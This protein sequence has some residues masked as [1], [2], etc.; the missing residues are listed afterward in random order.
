MID[1][2]IELDPREPMHRLARGVAS[3]DA[4]RDDQ[5]ERERLFETARA[6]FE[7]ARSLAPLDPDHTQN[8]AR[9]WA[10]R[11]FSA[12][13]DENRT[14]HLRHA[15]REYRSAISMRP[16]SAQLMM[17]L[18]GVLEALGETAELRQLVERAVELDPSSPRASIKLAALYRREAELARESGDQARADRI[19]GLGLQ[20]LERAGRED[21]GSAAVARAEAGLLVVAGRREDAITAYQRYMQR[22]GEDW[23]VHRVLAL[24][25]AEAGDRAA[26]IRHAER[27]MAVAG[28]GQ[29][30]IAAG[31]LRQVRGTSATGGEPQR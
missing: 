27:A 10:Q 13:G 9:M 19:L 25:H 15:E 26:A 5:A 12:G 29:K 3:T 20:V 8:L 22:F 21:P 28:P 24:L 7:T 14:G 23:E 1:R 16:Y 31:V 30:A 18:A 11:G 6:S 4:A 2:G 17:E